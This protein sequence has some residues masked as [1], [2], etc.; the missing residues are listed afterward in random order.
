MFKVYKF[1]LAALLVA[2]LVGCG[3]DKGSD[4][5]GSDDKGS[6]DKGSNDTIHNQGKSC[7]ACHDFNGATVFNSMNAPDNTAGAAGYRVQ[8]GG[9]DVYNSSNGIGNSNFRGNATLPNYT[10][11]VIDAN[12]NVVRSSGMN[13]HDNMR[14]DCNR[15][16]TA[17]GANGAPG[18]LTP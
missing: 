1:T 6:N 2:L 17:T 13:T 15:C 4:D 12:G 9:A 18:R 3:G 10:A 5:K 7:I 14:L 8:L 16:H 11:H